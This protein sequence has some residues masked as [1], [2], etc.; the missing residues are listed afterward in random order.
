MTIIRPLVAL[1]ALLS[2]VNGFSSMM[3]TPTKSS[4]SLMMQEGDNDDVSVSSRRQVLNVGLAAA[5]SLFLM[6]PESA[7]ATTTC[8]FHSVDPKT[9]VASA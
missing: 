9:F 1:F 4:S 3:P 5:A 6:N 8:K 7:S 2:S